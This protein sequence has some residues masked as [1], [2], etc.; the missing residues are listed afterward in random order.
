MTPTA[1]HGARFES[2]RPARGYFAMS[3]TTKTMVSSATVMI[4][5]R[6]LLGVVFI[7]ASVPKILNPQSFA[8]IVVN[9][10]ILSPALVNPAAI[11][12]P[13]TEALCGVCLISGRLV[14]GSA[15][16]F[17]ALMVIFLAA[18]AFN[19]YRGLDVNCG[20]FSVAAKKAHGSQLINLGRNFLLLVVG[21]LVLK[22]S[23]TADTEKVTAK[24]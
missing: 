6:V 24:I 3:A 17:V 2:D 7:W 12:L 11:V 18:T 16:I 14:R 15:L 21:V 5:L 10:R 22:S 1:G 20:C 9:Y 4:L 23:G 8:E 13:W 19:I